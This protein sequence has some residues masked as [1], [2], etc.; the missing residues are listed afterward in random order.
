VN[1]SVR[2]IVVGVDGS[3]SSRAAVRWAIEQA[4]LTGAS[5]DAVMAWK[6]PAATFDRMAG[7]EVD[8]EGTNKEALAEIIKQEGGPEPAAPVRLVV[9]E[10]HPADVLLRASRDADLLV[11]GSRGLGG[12]AS[13]VIGSVSLQCVLHAHC[14]VLVLRDGREGP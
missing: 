5:V 8:F 1:G 11:L 12:F 4:K 2:L 6:Y 7:A 10:G 13:A 14:P 9:T 3:Q